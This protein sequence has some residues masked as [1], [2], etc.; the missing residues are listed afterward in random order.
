MTLLHHCHQER[1]FI[2]ILGLDRIYLLLPWL[3]VI[4]DPMAGAPAVMTLV[5]TSDEPC[6][7]LLH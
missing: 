2:V 5:V 1:W 6:P 3:A 7:A 4:S